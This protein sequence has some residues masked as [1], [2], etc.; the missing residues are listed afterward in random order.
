MDLQYFLLLIGII[1][2]AVVALSSVDKARLLRRFRRVKFGKAPDEPFDTHV[3]PEKPARQEPSLYLDIN[4]SPPVESDKKFLPAVELEEADSAGDRPAARREPVVD[5]FYNE[6]EGVEEYARMPLNLN[7]GLDRPSTDGAP[8][9]LDPE[10]Q[11]MPDEKIDFIIH[12]PGV[13][14]VARNRALGIFKQHE[15]MLEKPRWLYGQ[16]YKTNYWSN[17][18]YDP[19]YTDYSNLA[20][21]IQL[22][23][24]E[25]PVEESELN[26]FMQL[27]LKLA[28][29]LHRPTKLPL[30]FEKALERARELREFCD[31]YDVIAGIN[32]VSPG[33]PPF[34][35]RAIFDAASELGM[36]FGAMNIF[37]MKNDRSPGCKHLFSMANLYK[38]GDFDPAKWD[39]FKTKGL[40]LFM[41][42]PCAHRPVSVFE[43]MVDTATALCDMLEGRLVD[44][45]GRPLT[46]K[47]IALIRRQIEEIAE[48]MRGRDIM[49]GSETALRLFGSGLDS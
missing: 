32:V 23:N 47:G 9:G 7:P 38:P 27:G 44:Q 20:L 42:V 31:T 17:L 18:Q 19:E 30:S 29:A 4:P 48:A 10:R 13:A 14:P 12:L 22:V 26:T 2:V 5:S 49:P 40:T 3:R 11:S 16:R 24:G 45:E 25:G 8:A 46:E 34:A 28:D 43:K 41:S 15:Y 1:I 37:H 35:G 39:K 33:G 36:Q 6:L 21:A